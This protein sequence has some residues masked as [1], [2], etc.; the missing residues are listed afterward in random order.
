MRSRSRTTAVFVLAAVVTTAAQPQAPKPAVRIDAV[1]G[2]V[3]AFKTHQVVMLPGGH[4]SKL[5]HDLLLA[6]LRD[7][8]VQGTLTDIV[9]EFGSSRYQDLIDRFMRGDEIAD[10]PLRRVWQD[11]RSRA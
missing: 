11:T 6:I 9:V 4:G 2:I 3:E 8:R 10:A 7:P 1:D 5:Y